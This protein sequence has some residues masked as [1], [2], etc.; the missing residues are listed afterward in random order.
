MERF[1]EFIVRWRKPIFAATI[2]VTALFA[3]LAFRVRLDMRFSDLQPAN[4]PFIQV[5]ERYQDHYGGALTAFLMVRVRSGDIYKPATLEKIRRITQ[6]VDALPGVNHDQVVSLASRKVKVVNISGAEISVNN[7]L[8]YEIPRTSDELR[9]LRDNVVAAGI[10]GTLVSTD[11]KAALVTAQFIE[12]HYDFVAVF[13][14]LR[15]IQAEEQDQNHEIFLAG[16]PVLM[17]WVSAYLPEILAI[18]AAT[19]GLMITLVFAY[20]RDWRLTVLPLTATA[21]S[22]IWGIGFVGV[23]GWP[24][25]PLILIVPVLLMARSLSHGLQ[26][27]ERMVELEEEVADSHDK[28]KALIRALFG[29]GLLGIVTDALG[30]LVIALAA[31]P[32]MRRLAYFGSFWAASMIVTV[33]IFISVAVSLFGGATRAGMKARFERSQISRILDGVAWLATGPRAR[34]VLVS[35]GAV[36]GAAI[37][38][39][40]QVAIGDVHPGTVLLWPESE[41]NT[42]VRRMNESFQGTDQL[43]VIVEAATKEG[44]R[45]PTVLKAM[46]DFQRT[47]EREPLIKATFSYADFM[48]IVR[49]QMNGNH[50]KWE[51]IPDSV[52]E[53]LQYSHLLLRG[54]DPGDFRRFV[55]DTYDHANIIVWLPDHRGATLEKVVDEIR[56]YVASANQSLKDSLQFR[57]ASGIAGVLA[58]VNEEVAVKQLLITISAVLIILTTCW[59]AF[60][61]WVAVIVLAVPLL[62]TD[63]IVVSVMALMEIGLDV[64]TL[65]IVSVGM[66]VGIDY[67]IYLLT[68]ILQEHRALGDYEASVTRAIKTTGRAIFFTATIMTLSAGLW[69]FLSSFRFL[70]EMGLLLALIMGINML[71]AL[72]VIPA[73]INVFRPRFPLDAPILR[74]E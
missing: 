7:L 38:G 66:G 73:W 29:S 40:T 56:E 53:A 44:V 30:I 27:V 5:H 18:L 41:F 49:R 4:H 47:L 25:D 28:A 69:Y 71:G 62:A 22:A 6:A 54:T 34:W 2:L 20:I 32:L 10:L 43:F 55:A 9:I 65:P 8:P 13:R 31:I 50:V 11:G 23:I 58:A 26:R 16:Q 35:F 51:Q 24:L 59:F 36:S 12:R 57:L 64:N 14:A 48:P 33:L 42:A 63:L 67:G 74:W 19:F 60:R 21:M 1:S 45:N 46:R 68:R 52:E 17:G 61:S 39:A 15:R 37:I 72:L 70:A 3:A